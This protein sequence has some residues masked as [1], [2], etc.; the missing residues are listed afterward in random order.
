MY[1]CTIQWAFD[2]GAEH[3]NRTRPFTCAGTGHSAHAAWTEPVAGA[4]V[5][6]GTFDADLPVAMVMVVVVAPPLLPASI[7]GTGKRHGCSVQNSRTGT[8]R[9]I[10]LKTIAAASE[11]QIR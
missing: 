3:V 1:P 7:P 8:M 4:S 11:R 5:P 9:S 10:H 2:S 6:R